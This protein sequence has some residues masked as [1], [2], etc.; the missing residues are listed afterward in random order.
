VKKVVIL[1]AFITF[2]TLFAYG[3]ENEPVWIPRKMDLAY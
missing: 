3:I 1:I 2:G